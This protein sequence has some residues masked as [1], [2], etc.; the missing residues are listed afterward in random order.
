MIRAVSFFPGFVVFHSHVFLL[1]LI[2]SFNLYTHFSYWNM[3][4]SRSG[5]LNLGIINDTLDH[6]ILHYEWGMRSLYS[7]RILSMGRFCA[8]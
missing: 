1:S 5:F 8:L 2:P 4:T 6:R 3:I 7:Q